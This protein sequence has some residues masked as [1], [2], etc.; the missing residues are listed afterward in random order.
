MFSGEPAPHITVSPR[1]TA[2][3]SSHTGLSDCP[4]DLLISTVLESL[5]RA[6]WKAKPAAGSHRP[7]AERSEP[8]R[9]G[10]LGGSSPAASPCRLFHCALAVEGSPGCSE[11]RQPGADLGD[12]FSLLGNPPSQT[13]VTRINTAPTLPRSLPVPARTARCDSQAVAFTR[14]VAGGARGRYRLFSFPS[15]RGQPLAASCSPGR[16]SKPPDTSG[17]VL[18]LL[19]TRT[20]VPFSGQTQCWCLTNRPPLRS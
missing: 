8:M 4:Q 19:V 2:P 13:Q 16:M 6:G 12:L 9:P 17:H 3:T 15:H 5:G 7:C 20:Q 11:S 18:P 14:W 10:P 1:S